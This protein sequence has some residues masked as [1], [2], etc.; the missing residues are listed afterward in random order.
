MNDRNGG[1]A[2]KELLGRFEQLHI[3]LDLVVQPE[4]SSK[5]ETVQGNDCNDEVV[6][7]KYANY[8]IWG[9]YLGAPNMVKW[10]VPEKVLQNAV[11]TRWF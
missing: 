5:R 11:Q 8:G 10:G 7:P 3:V 9:A 2:T 1:N 6:E 4:G